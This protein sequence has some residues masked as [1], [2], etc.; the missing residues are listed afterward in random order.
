MAGPTLR[1]LS[2]VTLVSPGGEYGGPVRVAVNQG[3]A[4]REQGH[5][6]VLAGAERGW[7]NGAPTS[8]EGVP[9][10]LFP[11]RTLVPGVGFAGVAA[12]GLWAWT[13]RHVKEFDVVHVHLARDLVT[14]P[15]ARMAQLRSV[16]TVLQTH[17]MI[18]PSSS[19]LAPV[20]DR[21]MTRPALRA[22][23]RV[24]CLTEHERALV[25]S[26][27]NKGVRTSLL[28][29]G[30][31]AA[32]QAPPPDRPTVLY[33][34]RLAPRKRPLDFVEAAR[35]VAR[36]FPATRFL[37]VGPDEGEGS[38]VRDAIRVATGEG[39]DITWQGP[40]EPDAV[41]ELLSRASIYVLPAVD[42]PYPMSVLEAMSIGVPVVITDS[43]GLA[44]AIDRCG[45]GH[46]VRPGADAVAE[47][48]SRLLQDPSAAQASG[49]RGRAL[50]S[51]DMSM[52]AVAHTLEEVYLAA[53]S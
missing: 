8:L 23:A 9:T 14:L 12:P 19:P 10:Q 13:S 37:M 4:L 30:V 20:I 40:V 43:C 42:E 47:A 35:K 46:V 3:A 50:V 16:P 26:V 39:V 5:D 25:L 15:T 6:V 51:L 44:S 2:V 33:L 24:L 17:G 31:P 11:A 38:A 22:A 18:D 7:I 49:R 53:R 29:N 1:I 32:P 41:R 45:G 34:A 27:E 36:E 48:V 52:E 28:V 21:S